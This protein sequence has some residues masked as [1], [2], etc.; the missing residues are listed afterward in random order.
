MAKIVSQSEEVTPR[1][2]D[3]DIVQKML[4]NEGHREVL[5]GQLR[6]LVEVILAPDRTQTTEADEK[7]A[8]EDEEEGNGEASSHHIKPIRGF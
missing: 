2:Y 5:E 8:V 3:K 1:I 4:M 7:P 6:S